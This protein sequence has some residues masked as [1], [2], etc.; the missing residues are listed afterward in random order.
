MEETL[1]EQ[2]EKDVLEPL[3]WLALDNEKAVEGR[4]NAV[5]SLE[6]RLAAAEAEG[7]VRVVPKIREKA[8]SERS[9]LEAA[10]STKTQLL[11]QAVFALLRRQL[12]FHQSANLYL[13]EVAP[14]AM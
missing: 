14:S 7:N 13:S 1:R 3:R 9:A 11:N 2:L 8:D 10:L 6:R 5:A 4:R 12:H